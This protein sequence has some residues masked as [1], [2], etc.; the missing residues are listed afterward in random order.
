VQNNLGTLQNEF[1]AVQNA[2]GSNANSFS[3][4]IKRMINS[5]L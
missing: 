5:I 1:V 3:I 4:S 2:R